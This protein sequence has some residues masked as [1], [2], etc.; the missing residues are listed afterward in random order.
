[1][2]AHDYVLVVVRN[3]QETHE[4]D[5]HRVLRQQGYHVELV[6][7]GQDPIP[8]MTARPPIAACYQFDYPDLQGLADLRQAKQRVASVPLLMV[9]QAHSES[10]AV[11]AFRSRV[12][13]YFVQPVDLAR[14]LEVMKTLY[15][16]RVPR[17]SAKE[18]RKAME[19][20]NQIPAEA[21]IRF[22]A[23][24]DQE[25]RL[26]L[27]ITFIDQHLHRKIAQ[28]EVAES[29]GLSAFQL[30]RLFRK[31]TGSTFQDYLLTRRITEAQRLLANPRVTVTD[32]C[33]SVGFRD[34][35]YFT[36]TFQKHVGHTPTAYRQTLTVKY[37]KLVH[38]S[39]GQS[40]CSRQ[41]GLSDSHL[42]MMKHHS[43]CLAR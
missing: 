5:Y 24:G 4:N 20:H 36:R 26:D 39:G 1:M 15:Q 2:Q 37:G 34:L 17:H 33:F 16:L 30:S 43:P 8:T 25:A 12:W 27:A 7:A 41:S 23:P 31:L 13:D 21:R 9:T 19:V 6:G 11:W 32:V 40:A 29:C 38:V 18:S 28:A 42:A 14:F 3:L 35:S 22:P 10:L